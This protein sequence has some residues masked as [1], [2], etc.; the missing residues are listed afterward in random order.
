MS[1]E[2]AVATLEPVEVT[3]ALELVE[4]VW[5]AVPEALRRPEALGG[6]EPELLAL[7]RPLLLPK[8]L[9]ERVRVGE[10]LMLPEPALPAAAAEADTVRLPVP[11]FP[12]LPLG[13]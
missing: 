11:L 9:P 10:P 8:L 13:L 12:A 3:V 2:S 5:E 7:A 1:S 4:K 6:T